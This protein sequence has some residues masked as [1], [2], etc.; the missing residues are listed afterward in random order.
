MSNGARVEEEDRAEVWNY[1]RGLTV[2]ALCVVAEAFIAALPRDSATYQ[3]VQGAVNAIALLGAASLGASL[4]LIHIY[5]TPIKRAIQA[6]WA[7]GTLGGL[8]LI[9]SQATLHSIHF[10]K[11]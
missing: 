6:L 2:A 3:T 5:V 10:S 11:T 1:R 9:A 7:C 8:W 4:A